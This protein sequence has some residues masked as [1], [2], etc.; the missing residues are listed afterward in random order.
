MTKTIEEIYTAINPL[1]AMLTDK[2]KRSPEVSVRIEANSRIDVSMNWTKRH[3]R[4]DWDKD[5]QHFF[6][7]TFEEAL[8]KATAFIREL[9]TADQA[10]LHD[11]MRQLGALIDAGKTDGISVDFMNP[12]LDTMKQLSEN[13]ITYKP[14]REPAHD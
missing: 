7:D 1:P 8:D 2:G 9:P 3:A 5:Y 10:K 12:L 14:Q 13:V 11:F 4:S 6:G